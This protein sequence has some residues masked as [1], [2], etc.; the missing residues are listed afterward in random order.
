MTERHA[1][2]AQDAPGFGLL[3]GIALAAVL[4]LGA[5]LVAGGLGRASVRV[6]DHTNDAVP[7]VDLRAPARPGVA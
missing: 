6:N 2:V 5:W 1:T 7:T 4:L 3:A